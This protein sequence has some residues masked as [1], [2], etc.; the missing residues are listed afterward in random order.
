MNKALVLRLSLLVLALASIYAIITN[1]DVIEFNNPQQIKELVLSSG[2][3]G[4]AIFI[5][6][7]CI[8]L[9]IYVPG[10][11]FLITGGLI[12]GPVKGS[13]IVLVGACAAVN[14]SFLV[15]R[16]VGGK[17]IKKFNNTFIQKCLDNLHQ[18]PI[19]NIAILRTVLITAPGF[20]YFLALSNVSFKQYFW[21]S[22]IGMILPVIAIVCFADIAAK[23][24][25]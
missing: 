7:F 9:L 13:I 4:I 10:M 15:V 5:S 25:L 24:F 16:L 20:N 22:L 6:L 19:K 17:P 21:G 2:S 1:S 11:L 23:Y 14:L 18:K 3:Y 8:G 12:Y